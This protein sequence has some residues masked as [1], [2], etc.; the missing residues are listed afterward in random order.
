MG[1]TCYSCSRHGASRCG[2]NGISCVSYDRGHEHCVQ[3]GKRGKLHQK[4]YQDRTRRKHGRSTPMDS[5]RGQ[6]PANMS[7]GRCAL[8]EENLRTRPFCQPQLKEGSQNTLTLYFLNLQ[9]DTGYI[10]FFSVC[11]RKAC[12]FRFFISIILAVSLLPTSLL[13][14]K[15]VVRAFDHKNPSFGP[16]QAFQI[17]GY[18]RQDP[19]VDRYWLDCGF[20]PLCPSQ[21]QNLALIY[22]FGDEG[23]RLATFWY[24]YATVCPSN[25]KLFFLWLAESSTKREFQ[26]LLLEVRLFLFSLRPC[27]PPLSCQYQ[28]SW[29]LEQKDEVHSMP[30]A[31]G[32]GEYD[33]CWCSAVFGLLLWLGI[34]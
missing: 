27:F 21:E 5:V 26:N 13:R 7:T 1:L 18:I 14:R 25:R 10:G 33:S 16:R 23:R 6:W 8:A 3:N 30:M 31:F 12:S 29:R 28:G 15:L 24:S 34:S 22:P 9:L 4:L 20:S 32:P 11:S 19:E 17:S 2:P